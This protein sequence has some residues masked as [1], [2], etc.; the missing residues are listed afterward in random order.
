[1]SFYRRHPFQ[2][3]FLGIGLV[4]GVA[5]WSAVQLINDHARASY[6]EADKV[7]GAE[8]RYWVRNPVGLGIQQS[9]YVELRKQGFKQIYP[10]IEVVKRTKNG[11]LVT[12]IA[13]DLLALGYDRSP[14]QASNPFAS[15][16][17]LNFVQP[18]YEAWYSPT[19]MQK[20]GI[21]EGASLIL[22]GGLQLPPARSQTQDQQ[23]ERIFMDAGAALK[24]L[25]LKRFSY[26]GVG[27]I[28]TQ[29]V[30]RLREEL[31][32]DL[33]LIQNEQALDLHQITESLHTNLNALGFLSFVVGM[34]IVFNAVRFSLLSRRSTVATLRE[35]GVDM[36]QIA[37][38]IF[39]ESFLISIMGA[40]F[41]L[42]IGTWFGAEMLPSVSASLQNLYGANVPGSI[43]STLNMFP[44]TLALTMLGV[45][46][47]LVLP[48]YQSA[49]QVVRSERNQAYELQPFRAAI[50][51]SALIG[52]G[53]I[54]LAVF[55]FR[56]VDNVEAGFII[57]GF[58][59]FGG[60]LMLPR[61]I[62]SVIELAARAAPEKSI[63]VR[64]SIR[65]TLLQ[66]PHLRI[67]LMALLLTLVANIGVTL[68][69]GSFRVALSDWLDVRLSANIFIA[70]DSG[71]TYANLQW[72]DDIHTRYA[73]D[74]RF[75]GRPASIFGVTPSAPDFRDLPLL[76][77]M[78][79]A[80]ARW[81]AGMPTAGAVPIL[82]NEQLHFLKGVES[83]AD[84]FLNS[85]EFEVVGFL[86]DY[87]NQNFRFGY[88]KQSRGP[89]SITCASS[90]QL[91]G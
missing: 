84:N 5:L 42:L 50:K 39:T 43:E 85:Q 26:L 2:A 79:N 28:N 69:V 73:K 44:T 3:L 51:T 30:K 16:A 1:M 82:A 68:L 55:G 23:G 31:P 14:G 45:S 48:L 63:L 74:L 87:G 25:N 36:S 18:D 35:L 49:L 10:V 86:H 6:A 38:A 11:E 29:E 34:F 33:I 71:D 22:T 89:T 17:W 32:G 65:D 62:V 15:Q 54:A 61:L 75:E 58:V 4:T 88:L 7:L 56:L 78:P 8:A 57:I 41:G 37:T 24:S 20:L 70:G 40:G 64:W 67:A 59:M 77:S 9:D 27:E 81:R 60:A 91:Y 47:A 52:G 53:L 12:I 66:L 13:T 76:K 46:L 72:V 83:W 90:A 80:L 19:L 21:I